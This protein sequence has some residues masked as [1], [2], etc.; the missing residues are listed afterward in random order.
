M[1]I[2][3][4]EQVAEILDHFGL[5]I[6][7][8]N[9]SLVHHAIEVG[10]RCERSEPH[11]PPDYDQAAKN[12]Q[13]PPPDLVLLEGPERYENN[14]TDIDTKVALRLHVKFSTHTS[15][16]SYVPRLKLLAQSHG[17]NGDGRARVGPAEPYGLDTQ[18]CWV[19]FYD[20][21]KT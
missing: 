16:V 14:N 15:F 12:W 4:R 10:I 5:P 17:F 1:R 13:A 2:A 6:T 8:T 21:I 3:S 7:T 18:S 19:I 11:L 9:V 20:E